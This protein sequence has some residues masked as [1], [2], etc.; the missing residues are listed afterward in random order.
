MSSGRIIGVLLV[1]GIIAVLI[2]SA[3]TRRDDVNGVPDGE[4]R[5]TSPEQIDQR[6]KGFALLEAMRAELDSVSSADE[7]KTL[8]T[9]LR[10]YLNSLS[11]E[12]SASLISDFLEDPGRDAV[13]GIEFSVGDGGSLVGHPSIRVALLDWLGEIDPARAGE[14]AEEILASPTD[15]D[16]WAVC[17]RNYAR[18]YPGAESREFLRTKTEEL[19]RNANWSESPSAGFLES[20]DVLVHIRATESAPLLGALVAEIRPE[21]RAA[22]HAAYLSLDRLTIREPVAMMKALAAQPELSEVRGPMV[23]NMFARADLRDETHRRL[24][25]EY[26]LDPARTEEELAAFAGVYPNNNYA[27]SKN[28]LTTT[29][30]PS[31]AELVAHDD[32]VIKI[33]RQWLEDPA[34]EPVKPHLNTMRNR[35]TAFVDSASQ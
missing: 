19:I 10:A 32:A 7:A 6:S 23:G 11:P 25:R 3:L 2:F 5:S 30:A 21:G 4:T 14:V 8:L 24:V 9:G 29:D 20:F 17:L 22:A 31:G 12:L 33:V 1:F 26:L 16:E 34:F 28:L 15:P 35:L 18:A 27:I 13:T